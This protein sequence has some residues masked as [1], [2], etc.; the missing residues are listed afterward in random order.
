M[1]SFTRRE[2]S[3]LVGGGLVVGPL[4]CLRAED[5]QSRPPAGPSIVAGVRLGAQTYSFR[6]RPLAEVPAAFK[7]VG[8]SF[9]ELWAGH[10]ETGDVI[11][12]TSR[13]PRDERNDLL[14]TW[15]LGVPMSRG[16]A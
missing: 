14:R 6:H 12:A 3:A 7:A 16:A 10:V 5:S 1:R 11:G 15:R 8:L 2:W 9:C 13:M 4:A